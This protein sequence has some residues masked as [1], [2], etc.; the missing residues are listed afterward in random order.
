MLSISVGERWLCLVKGRKKKL[1]KKL[2]KKF[3]E[4]K[5]SK[6]NCCEY[7]CQSSERILKYFAR[8][9]I[10]KTEK[11]ATNKYFHCY[12]ITPSGSKQLRHLSYPM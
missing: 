12:S 4:S 5:L 8:V 7:R 6:C 11:V 2:H 1:K 3:R 10:C 9:K